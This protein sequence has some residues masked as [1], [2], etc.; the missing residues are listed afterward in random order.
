LTYEIRAKFYQTSDFGY[1]SFKHD[2]YASPSTNPQ[3]LE[4]ILNGSGAFANLDAATRTRISSLIHD[5]NAPTPWP[6]F[7]E[8]S[9]QPC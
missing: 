9:K 8:C 2:W 3:Q 4:K 5:K 1:E 6:R 7:L